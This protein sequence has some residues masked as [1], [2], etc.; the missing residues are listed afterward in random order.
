MEHHFQ[1]KRPFLKLAA[2]V[3]LICFT[4]ETAAAFPGAP[5]LEKP[6]GTKTVYL[7]LNAHASSETQRQIARLLRFFQ[8]KGVSSIGLEG[9]SDPID[10]RLF[11]TFPEKN[12]LAQAAWEMVREGKLTGAEYFYITAEKLPRFYGLEKKEFYLRNREAF[13]RTVKAGERIRPI[14]EQAERSLAGSR[15]KILSPK[16]QRFLELNERFQARAVRSG[17]YFPLLLESAKQARVS[18]VDFPNLYL[19]SRAL[20]ESKSEISVQLTEG[21]HKGLFGEE[22]EALTEKI[23]GRLAES[24]EEKDLIDKIQ[25]LER[26]KSLLRLELQSKDWEQIRKTGAG[27]QFF[28]TL[29]LS[30]REI[31]SL[32]EAAR[33]ALRFYALADR[34]DRIFAGKILRELSH[35]RL[36]ATVAVV[37]GFHETGLREGLERAGITVVPVLPKLAEVLDDIPYRD[38][39]ASTLDI[40][41][42]ISSMVSLQ[43]KERFKTQ[44]FR[45]AESFSRAEV[46]GETE[47]PE[48]IDLMMILENVLKDKELHK[49]DRP[50]LARGQLTALFREI[51]RIIMNLSEVERQTFLK[52]EAPRQAKLLARKLPDG[53]RDTASD[54]ASGDRAYFDEKVPPLKDEKGEIVETEEVRHFLFAFSQILLEETKRYHQK[55]EFR[56]VSLIVGMLLISLAWELLEWTAVWHLSKP[57]LKSAVSGAQNEYNEWRVKITFQKIEKYH[58][59]D[60]NRRHA[61]RESKEELIRLIKGEGSDPKEKS[62]EEIKNLQKAMLYISEIG[63]EAKETIPHLMKRLNHRSPDVRE[64]A[65]MTLAR[66]FAFTEPTDVQKAW[67]SEFKTRLAETLKNPDEFPKVRL[68]ALA[69]LTSR[70]GFV[71]RGIGDWI[72]LYVSLLKDPRLRGD[73]SYEI[74]NL[75]FNLADEGKVILIVELAALLKEPDPQV[76]VAALVLI[77][78]NLKPLFG[79]SWPAGFDK[80]DLF[81]SVIRLAGDKDPSVADAARN[82][83]DDWDWIELNA[84]LDISERITLA[85]EAMVQFKK[86]GKAAGSVQEFLSQIL[87]D[88]SWPGIE[89][90][91]LELLTL[92]KEGTPELQKMAIHILSADRVQSLDNPL[93]IPFVPSL[94]DALRQETDPGVRREII[95]IFKSMGEQAMGA[96]PLLIEILKE[97]GERNP[98]PVR[99]AV[100]KALWWIAIGYGGD[101]TEILD[102]LNRIAM[103]EAEDPALRKAAKRFYEF[104][105]GIWDREEKMEESLQGLKEIRKKMEEGTRERKET[106]EKPGIRSEKSRIEF[107]EEGG[108]PELR[109]PPSRAEVRTQDRSDR[110]LWDQLI[111][112]GEGYKEIEESLDQEWRPLRLIREFPKMVKDTVRLTELK[113]KLRAI[114]GDFDEKKSQPSNPSAFQKRLV[115][116]EKKVRK[117]DWIVTKNLAWIGVVM[118]W[119][120]SLVAALVYFLSG[121]ILMAVALVYLIPVGIGLMV[122]VKIHRSHRK[123]SKSQEGNDKQ[124]KEPTDS[125]PRAEVRREIRHPERGPFGPSEGSETRDPSHP[126][127]AQ[128][129]VVRAEVRGKAGAEETIDGM[130][131]KE[132]DEE[133]NDLKTT[134]R[135]Q[136]LSLGLLALGLL[137][138]AYFLWSGEL[139]LWMFPGYGNLPVVWV[140]GTL[141]GFLLFVFLGWQQQKLMKSL[142]KEERAGDFKGID[143][144]LGNIPLQ[145]RERMRGVMKEIWQQGE[146]PLE[147]EVRDDSGKRTILDFGGVRL[148]ESQTP[149]LQVLRKTKEETGGLTA[150]NQKNWNHALDDLA[151]SLALELAPLIQLMKRL[152]SFPGSE[153]WISVVRDRA[154]PE[155]RYALRLHFPLPPPRSGVLAQPRETIRSLHQGLSHRIQEERPDL[156]D[157]SRGLYL[158]TRTSEAHALDHLRSLGKSG[159]LKKGSKIAELGS[160][161]GYVVHL[162]NAETQG[163]GVELFGFEQDRYLWK[164]SQE[165]TRALSEQGAVDP[166]R[167]HILHKNYLDEKVSLREYDV[168]Y[169]YPSMKGEPGK[170]VVRAAE[171]LTDLSEVVLRMK[172]GAILIVEGVPPE[173]VLRVLGDDRRYVEK[174]PEVGGFRRIGPA[175]EDVF[176]ARL[177]DSLSRMRKLAASAQGGPGSI[178]DVLI[179]SG[180]PEAYLSP[181]SVELMKEFL[182]LQAK[183]FEPWAEWVLSGKGGGL[184]LGSG[185]LR[186]GIYALLKFRDFLAP[187]HSEK[188]DRLEQA[189]LVLLRSQIE[190]EMEELYLKLKEGSASADE[191]RPLLILGLALF[192]LISLSQAGGIHK[193][194]TTLSDLTSL[195]ELLGR[196]FT[197]RSG[198]KW[199][200]AEK[201]RFLSAHEP[202]RDSMGLLPSRLSQSVTALE[203]ESVRLHLAALGVKLLERMAVHAQLGDLI[204][205]ELHSYANLIA[206]W[207]KEY[208]PPYWKDSFWRNDLFPEVHAPTT[209]GI[210]SEVRGIE[211]VR[212]ETRSKLDL[213]QPFLLDP[214]RRYDP[215]KISKYLWRFGNAVEARTAQASNNPWF[216]WALA[217]AGSLM[218]SLPVWLLQWN[219]IFSLSDPLFFSL[220]FS[221]LRKHRLRW[222]EAALLRRLRAAVETPDDLWKTSTRAKIQTLRILWNYLDDPDLRVRSVAFDILETMGRELPALQSQLHDRKSQLPENWFDPKEAR[223]PVVFGARLEGRSEMRSVEV[224][225]G[226]EDFKVEEVP[227]ERFKSI[228]RLIERYLNSEQLGEFE[229]EALTAVDLWLKSNKVVKLWTLKRAKSLVGFHALASDDLTSLDLTGNPLRRIQAWSGVTGAYG[230]SRRFRGKGLGKRL[231]SETLKQFIGERPSEGPSVRFYWLL[232]DTR[233]LES[234]AMI[235]SVTRDLG[236]PL[237][238]LGSTGEDS[239]GQD[240]YAIDLSP[241][242]TKPGEL[243]GLELLPEETQ[244]AIARVAELRKRGMARAEVRNKEGGPAPNRFS[245]VDAEGKTKG[246]IYVTP[247]APAGGFDFG[248]H[249]DQAW[250]DFHEMAFDFLKV[251]EKARAGNLPVV[252]VVP[253]ELEGYG[254]LH[255]QAPWIEGARVAMAWASAYFRFPDKDG[256]KVDVRILKTGKADKTPDLESLR[257]VALDLLVQKFDDSKG[258][259]EEQIESRQV[260]IH[261]LASEAAQ[262][263]GVF[264]TLTFEEFQ[265]PS[266]EKREPEIILPPPVPP[267]KKRILVT[268]VAG[269][270]GS[271]LARRLVKEGHQVIGLDNLASGVKS[272]LK[273]LQENPNFFFKNVD[274]SQ[275]YTIDGELD[276]IIHLAS[277]ASPPFYYGMPLETL[278][279]GLQATKIALDLAREKKARFLFSST[280]EVYGD[281]DVEAQDENYPGRVNPIGKRSQYDESKR[282][283]ETLI[284][285]YFEKEKAEGHYLDARIVRI[286]NTYG[287]GMRLDDGRVITNFIQAALD[288][289]WKSTYGTGKGRVIE[290]YGGGGQNRSFGF[291]ADTLEGIVGLLETGEITR[292]TPIDGRVVNIGN[293]G[294]FTIRELA[295][296]VEELGRK[297][298]GVEVPVVDVSQIDSTDPKQRQPVIERARRLFGY[299]PKVPLEAGL[300]KTFRHFV[301]RE[302]WTKLIDRGPGKYDESDLKLIEALF[303]AFIYEALEDPRLGPKI[304]GL[305]IPLE[306]PFSGPDEKF[307][308]REKLTRLAVFMALEGNQNQK[309]TALFLFILKKT[310]LIYDAIAARQDQEKGE[311]GTRYQRS[312]DGVDAA[313]NLAP[314]DRGLWGDKAM[315]LVRL[316]VETAG[317]KRFRDAVPLFEEAEKILDD[318]RQGLNGRE[319]QAARVHLHLSKARAQISSPK[320]VVFNEVEE[321]RK[322]KEIAYSVVDDFRLHPDEEAAQMGRLYFLLAS[323]ELLSLKREAGWIKRLRLAVNSLYDIEKSLEFRTN[324]QGSRRHSGVRILEESLHAVRKTLEEAKVDSLEPGE[325]RLL[326]EELA[327]LGR[328]LDS[329]T[330]NLQGKNNLKL[331]QEVR[332]NRAKK[333]IEIAGYFKAHPESV[334]RIEPKRVSEKVGEIR[335]LVLPSVE[336]PLRLFKL[337]WALIEGFWL[338]LDALQLEEWIRKQPFRFEVGK[339]ALE[340]STRIAFALL[341][342]GGRFE[343]F[344]FQAYAE[345]RRWREFVDPEKFILPAA[346][347][348]VRTEKGSGT[349]PDLLR[350]A[351][352]DLGRAH[353]ELRVEKFNWGGQSEAVVGRQS[354]A[355]GRKETEEPLW[356]LNGSPS[357]LSHDRGHI[358]EIGRRLI[359]EPLWSLEENYR[360]VLDAL[361][362]LLTNPDRKGEAGWLFDSMRVASRDNRNSEGL[363]VSD[364]REPAGLMPVLGNDF[365]FELTTGPSTPAPTKGFWSIIRAAVAYEKK[366]PGFF[367]GKVVADGGTG[368]GGI[369]TALYRWLA[370][371]S[372]PF[373]KAVAVDLNGDAGT[374]LEINRM[375]NEIPREKIDFFISPYFDSLPP[376]AKFDVLFIN[377]NQMPTPEEKEWESQPAA[378]ASRIRWGRTIYSRSDHYDGLHSVRL[379][380]QKAIPRLRQDGVIFLQLVDRIDFEKTVKPLLDELG[381]EFEVIKESII[382]DAVG[383]D[384]PFEDFLAAEQRTETSDRP[385][386][387]YHHYD[388]V[389]NR[390]DLKK[391]IQRHTKAGRPWPVFRRFRTL[392][393]QPKEKEVVWPVAPKELQ[394]SLPEKIGKKTEDLEA[395][396][397]VLA[398]LGPFKIF[399]WNRE[400]GEEGKIEKR[401]WGAWVTHD[402][403]GF[404]R[405][406]RD[407]SRIIGQRIESKNTAGLENFIS[408]LRDDYEEMGMVYQVWKAAAEAGLEELRRKKAEIPLQHAGTKEDPVPDAEWF[409][410]F[411]R[412]VFVDQPKG[413]KRFAVFQKAVRRFGETLPELKTQIDE[414]L[415]SASVRLRS[416]VRSFR[417]S[418]P[419]QAVKNLDL[420]KKGESIFEGADI[421]S[422]VRNSEALD[423]RK[424]IGSLV[425]AKAAE[426]QE[427]YRLEELIGQGGQGVIFKALNLATQE[428]VA[429]KIIHLGGKKMLEGINSLTAEAEALRK[430]M[431]DHWEH[432][433]AIKSFGFIDKPSLFWMAMDY[434]GGENLKEW[435]VGRPAKKVV[436]KFL[437]L[438]D[439]IETLHQ[440]GVIHRDLKP[441]HMRVLPDQGLKLIDFGL[442]HIRE[443]DLLSKLRTFGSDL[444]AGTHAYQ[445]PM[446]WLSI[447]EEEGILKAELYALGVTL[448]ELANGSPLWEGWE[449]ESFAMFFY[450][451]TRMPNTDEIKGKLPGDWEP[452]I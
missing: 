360:D 355:G 333:T 266:G 150:E 91:A 236:L 412:H 312:L 341:R 118:G 449:P 27:E 26:L 404:L 314:G 374:V 395:L 452:A 342:H 298:L 295:G 93:V 128:D 105:K 11:R 168:V 166:E 401:K 32:Q 122:L 68:A 19:F 31:R 303:R 397:S 119:V 362:R 328:L 315:I 88:L 296:L 277:L 433:P 257:A 180:V 241:N 275:P 172:P 45:R 346:R 231:V 373:E 444:F 77:S 61:I 414:L 92:A 100:T 152:H 383:R 376:D 331:A 302:L 336:D 181:R 371:H 284:R 339:T 76:K 116:W 247:R 54:W 209:Q 131:A 289:F 207:V 200:E 437:E 264:K 229:T 75:L 34:R 407:V 313:L 369:L 357:S 282:G 261:S 447:Q 21:I 358:E 304:K 272:N 379:W 73:V 347:A 35:S 111:T 377:P 151:S 337:G 120:I 1:K 129:D 252:L 384:Y 283:A 441:S 147:A 335:D 175:Y 82:F 418:E 419:S 159:H 149:V 195:I 186:R 385:G 193:G 420:K 112:V 256:R 90:V 288:Q 232:I 286:F 299:K 156:W 353:Q 155:G 212:S 325:V 65:I 199:P 10:G 417:H 344:D 310:P 235:R 318:P 218:T 178:T 307:I 157:T 300:E 426:G 135:Y 79:S 123:H 113:E 165:A 332:A 14:V 104:L 445:P 174:M 424:L 146:I 125:A 253:E 451:H 279:A 39:L 227:R 41:L 226:S 294:N 173:S 142:D 4:S 393:L 269:F 55:K 290:L 254:P 208:D 410:A 255:D 203:S 37:G 278:L 361:Y 23:Y 406:I 148:K 439:I 192:A 240:Y 291:V 365:S 103:D 72:P 59:I 233:Q 340:D 52:E 411:V 60:P 391:S 170:T 86:G 216:P 139:S 81:R 127:G 158:Y 399:V 262:E 106:S 356:L 194:K 137:G 238:W 316:A 204:S 15:E 415:K 427:Q 366:Y 429:V 409:N 396:V 50:T 430:L 323:A 154:P 182:G 381:L 378:E 392:V 273:D 423:W 134:I 70:I 438:L 271:N 387:R 6:P 69:A 400:E 248:G 66:L 169:L 220:L 56:M 7:L 390:I 115:H 102:L 145:D 167:I 375:R 89:S 163:L 442:S 71:P 389:G 205:A 162:W 44:L 326:G 136:I 133:V 223:H 144:A 95:L 448:F 217:A 25:S 270:L 215:E 201:V 5:P 450:Q 274:V 301:V 191:A 354:Q 338:D 443:E 276:E 17:E 94:M 425:P 431:I 126:A 8:K 242:R 64:A 263:D 206:G 33:P 260:V 293:P 281:P 99:E 320:E 228:L 51:S 210:R 124:S 398:G 359:T 348:E 221:A 214:L 187:P 386:V 237:Y 225:A 213:N 413:E 368:H 440:L 265:I 446:G 138:S 250:E 428:I 43:E 405:R 416:E 20:S 80:V 53:M 18:L 370:R 189:H 352:D 246:L 84:W 422:E 171:I 164:L 153:V 330:L 132:V 306:E 190:Q 292:S 322:A 67:D 121:Q 87:E 3:T 40:K 96:V 309:L 36:K 351:R 243:S 239:E 222:G 78:D 184:D 47:R 372:A 183:L 9:A 421:R 308:G 408:V 219:P 188:L 388:G 280:S 63:S 258:S 12:A 2:L 196:Y 343:D 267:G 161:T 350:W 202:S 177:T 117:L 345:A 24:K 311:R 324:H 230:L 287:P 382:D 259:P 107:E 285:L 234:F 367:K 30:K 22:L 268:G 435:A 176:E 394:G 38:R 211:G 49:G 334:R 251:L 13:I 349:D 364:Y 297:Y 130:P 62:P 141:G 42:V 97:K 110:D 85:Q 114:R 198:E 98:P 185:I 140:A 249:L 319:D 16:L 160:G 245:I 434:L 436:W 74:K 108:R 101:R 29:G 83:L 329:E 48:K 380:L 224:R 244:E 432:A 58:T 317:Q 305:E 197:P 327:K 321:L 28:A 46:R 179:L 403:G 143:E 57:S 109:T 363:Q 402:V